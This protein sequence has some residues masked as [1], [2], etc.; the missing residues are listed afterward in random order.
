MGVSRC[1]YRLTS[2]WC[3][4]V[5]ASSMDSVSSITAR[6]SCPLNCSR[7]N[8]HLFHT[9]RLVSR[10]FF[11][12]SEPVSGGNLNNRIS[13]LPRGNFSARA[14]G[15]KTSF[16]LAAA[17]FSVSFYV[18]FPCCVW[19]CCCCCGCSFRWWISWPPA[20]LYC[21]ASSLTT[22]TRPLPCRRRCPIWRWS[23]PSG[24][25]PSLVERGLFGR[26]SL[27][28]R[29]PCCGCRCRW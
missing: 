16:S 12:V 5:K 1:M 7:K 24:W 3:T 23:G 9:R 18:F 2:Q 6:L 28:Q 14:I 11:I 26:H 4:P 15:W 8:R 20:S 27:R 22:L 25:S 29:P 10:N 17:R 21:V 13:F 19:R